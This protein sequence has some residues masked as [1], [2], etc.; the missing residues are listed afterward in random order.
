MIKVFTI[1]KAIKYHIKNKLAKYF[2]DMLIFKIT[3]YNF[4]NLQGERRKLSKANQLMGT[5]RREPRSDRMP[6]KERLRATNTNASTSAT[7]NN[8]GPRHDR[9]RQNGLRKNARLPTTT[10][11]PH[12]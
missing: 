3:Y 6:K 12:T 7:H 9:H 5:M 10:L 4:K 11:P 8:V 1:E 2:F